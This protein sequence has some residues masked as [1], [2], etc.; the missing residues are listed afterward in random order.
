MHFSGFFW[1]WLFFMHAFP[2]HNS[3]PALSTSHTKLDIFANIP[4][5]LGISQ[6]ALCPEASRERAP[7]EADAAEPTDHQLDLLVVSS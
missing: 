7:H 2:F 1:N 5:V 6:D 3:R 4:D